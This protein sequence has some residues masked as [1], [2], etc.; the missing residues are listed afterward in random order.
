MRLLDRG[1]ILPQVRLHEIRR[2]HHLGPLDEGLAHFLKLQQRARRGGQGHGQGAQDVD[3]AAGVRRPQPL[4]RDQFLDHTPAQGH[5]HAFEAG[6]V[7]PARQA[8]GMPGQRWD[9]PG[10]QGVGAGQRFH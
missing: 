4:Q 7:E 10:H 9:K 2:D 1:A 5:A 3:L 6:I 8:R